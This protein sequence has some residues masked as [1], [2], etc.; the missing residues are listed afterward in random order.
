MVF[1]ALPHALGLRT[2]YVD[3]MHVVD[4]GYGFTRSPSP[5][6]GHNPVIADSFDGVLYG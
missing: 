6:G 2:I 4:L 5:L 1:T 3:M